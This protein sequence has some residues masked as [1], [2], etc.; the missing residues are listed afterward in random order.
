MD[1]HANANG[2]PSVKSA[3]NDNLN[4]IHALENNFAILINKGFALRPFGKPLVLTSISFDNL[5]RKIK[6]PCLVIKKFKSIKEIFK[7]KILKTKK[8]FTYMV[9]GALVMALSISCKS[10]EEPANEIAGENPPAGSYTN[11]DYFS[12]GQGTVAINPE[13]GSC[14]IEGTIEFNT[15]GA[16]YKDN[17]T[18]TFNITVNSWYK[19]YDSTIGDYSS[20]NYTRDYVVNSFTSNPEGYALDYFYWGVNSYS[21]KDFLNFIINDSSGNHFGSQSLNTN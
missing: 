2:T 8:L 6:N 10:N 18:I 16:I 9:V 17:V 21:G 1:C 7:M 11:G 4:Y 20:F 13:D 19:P 5:S 14:T 15:N 12:S 3:R